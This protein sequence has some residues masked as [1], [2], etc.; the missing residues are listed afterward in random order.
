MIKLFFSS[1]L[2][3]L[4]GDDR[5]DFTCELCRDKITLDVHAGLM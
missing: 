5:T 2:D 3:V 1:R 4:G